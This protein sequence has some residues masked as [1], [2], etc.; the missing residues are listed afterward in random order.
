MFSSVI[1]PGTCGRPRDGI[2]CGVKTLPNFLVRQIQEVTEYT[3]SNVPPEGWL[4]GRARQPR[5]LDWPGPGGR[6][7]GRCSDT[8]LEAE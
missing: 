3:Q 7:A 8:H 1:F 4:I 6:S 2:H 5:G